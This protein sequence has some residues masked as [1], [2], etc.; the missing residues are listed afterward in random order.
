MLGKRGGGID[1]S[2]HAPARGA[3]ALLDHQ[4]FI[5]V[6]ST[7]APA[8]GATKLL[9]QKSAAALIST[10]AP[11][12]GATPNSSFIVSRELFQPTL[13]HEERHALA[14]RSP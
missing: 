2:T 13:L 10:H 6:I 4:A 7:H 11:A 14:T 3:T 12:R 8:R 9:G 1:I 5:V